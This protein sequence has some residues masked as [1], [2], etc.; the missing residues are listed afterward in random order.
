MQIPEKFRAQRASLRLPNLLKD[1]TMRL[2]ASAGDCKD[3]GG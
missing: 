2:L 1:C 3:V